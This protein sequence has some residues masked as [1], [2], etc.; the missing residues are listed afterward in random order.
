MSI[1]LL[2]CCDLCAAA[3]DFGDT[4]KCNLPDGCTPPVAITSNATSSNAAFRD[5][6]NVWGFTTSYG[7]RSY[8]AMRGTEDEPEWIA[9][10]EAIPME[11]LAAWQCSVHR[12]VERVYRSLT[13]PEAPHNSIFTGH[14]LGAALARRAYLQFGGECAVFAPPLGGNKEFAARL[15]DTT[16][17]ENMGDIVPQLPRGFGFRQGGNRVRVAGPVAAATITAYFAQAHSLVSY[18]AGLVAA[19]KGVPA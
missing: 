18:R 15:T 10:F 5:S 16:W 11:F 14:S 1:D 17:V 9:D 6:R 19:A 13:F 3:Y 7:G 2:L 8:A 4:G 12:G